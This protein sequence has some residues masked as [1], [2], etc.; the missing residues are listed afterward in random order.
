MSAFTGSNINQREFAELSAE[1][2]L[3]S[4]DVWDQV[5]EE[6]KRDTPGRLIKSLRQMTEKEDFKFTS[7]LIDPE[8]PI[9]EMITLGPIP[10]YT[11]CVHHVLPF[12]GEAWISYIPTDRIA[13]LS[14]FARVVKWCAKGLWVQETLTQA[15]AKIIDDEL[16]PLGVG[17]VLKAEHL[18]MA[19]RGVEVAGVRTTTSTMKGVFADHNRTAKAEFLAMIK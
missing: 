15:I 17:V 7:F 2:L 14:K 16:K 9:D 6:H 1:N 18:C 4:L 3:S 13:G 11:L 12:F 19:M 8:D 5:P 10:F